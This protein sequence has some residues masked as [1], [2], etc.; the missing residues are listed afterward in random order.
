MNLNCSLKEGTSTKSGKKY[1]YLSI[2][3]TS[4]LE[5]K[6]FLEDAELELLKMQGLIGE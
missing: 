1:Y 5:K 2:Y 3:L 6:V 4:S